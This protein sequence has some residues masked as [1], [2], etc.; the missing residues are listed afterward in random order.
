MK[1]IKPKPL[2]KGDTIALIS[3]SA[4]L[5][6]IFPH[7]LDN[8]IKFLEREGFKVKEFSC[9]RKMNGWESAPAEERAK[10]IMA[11]FEDPEVKAIIC[12]IG[13]TVANQT[14][15]Y[16]DFEKIRNN[17]KIFCG[18]SDITN[19]H[20]AIFTKSK[21]STFYGPCAMTQFAEYPKP[22]Q[23]TLDYFFKAVSSKEPI[24]KIKASKEWTDETLN[25]GKKLDLERARNLIPNP[26]YV[27]L[28]KGKAEGNLIGGCLPSVTHLA[29]TSFWPDYKNSILF[30]E[31]PE[32]QEFDK[33]EPPSYVDWYLEHLKLT[34]VFDKIKGLIF[35]RPFKYSE[36]DVEK[37]KKKIVERTSDYDFP[38]L[39][40]AD[41]GHTDPMIT[42]PLGVR[43]EVDSDTNSFII[44]E[45]ATS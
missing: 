9:T 7:R 30:L 28:R 15:K 36:K 29:G 21:L 22:L 43:A 32:G 13:G 8:A 23:Y 42:I 31:I 18:Y 38:I 33:G 40:G 39:F 2:N 45:P 19:L 10:D 27:W 16:L 20:Y 5:V 14:L 24:G 12:T 35:G 17:P 26:S 44:L 37:L 11:A 1:L 4:G 6:P 41:I 3:P 25:W 34:G